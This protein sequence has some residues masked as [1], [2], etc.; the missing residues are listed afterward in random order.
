MAQGEVLV[1]QVYGDNNERAC[2]RV[3]A[4][5]AGYDYSRGLPSEGDVCVLRY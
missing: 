2:D 5:R 1:F 3:G 4:T